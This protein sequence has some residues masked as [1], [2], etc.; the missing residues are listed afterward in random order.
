MVVWPLLLTVANVMRV[1]AY[2]VDAADEQLALVVVHAML[3][4]M[5]HSTPEGSTRV[6]SRMPHVIVKLLGQCEVL[7]RNKCLEFRA[8][9][10]GHVIARGR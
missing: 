9:K 7:G 1:R 6:K 4:A 2:A 3:C 10:I 8:T 5:R